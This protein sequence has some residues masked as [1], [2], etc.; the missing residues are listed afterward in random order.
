[1]KF[2]YSE[3]LLYDI[4]HIGT[5]SSTEWPPQSSY[6]V[7]KK[8]LVKDG[9]E[10]E[11]MHGISCICPSSVKKSQEQTAS[12]DLTQSIRKDK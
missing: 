5:I 7:T 10:A 1:M 4:E 8:V 2:E 3:A 11:A 6:V 12:I 9:V